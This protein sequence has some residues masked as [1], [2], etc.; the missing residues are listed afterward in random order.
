MKVLVFGASNS[1][2]S[3]NRR[4]ALFCA[5]KIKGAELIVLDLND[6]EMPIY[7]V[8]REKN[9]G[10]PELAYTFKNIL[11]SVDSVVVSFAE[12]N[13]SYSVAFKNIM[14]WMSRIEG[15]IWES[16]PFFLLTTSPGRRGGKTVLS[17]ARER[18][19]YMGAKVISSFSL[20]SFNHNFND[21]I[22]ITDEELR[23]D[24]Q[25]Q[26]DHFIASTS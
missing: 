2:T 11:K 13:G 8:D 16:K 1:S 3:I 21:E 20:P 19:G 24:F 23:L 5:Q 18:F 15:D 4:F 22:G 26:L 17:I 25:N 9:S 12:H 14:D 10:I 7:S 6:F